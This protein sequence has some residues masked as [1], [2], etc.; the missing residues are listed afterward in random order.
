MIFIQWLISDFQLI[1]NN[2]PWPICI[3]ISQNSKLHFDFAK[4]PHSLHVLYLA[5]KSL[6][7]IAKLELRKLI[8]EKTCEIRCWRTNWVAILFVNLFWVKKNNYLLILILLYQTSSQLQRCLV[9]RKFQ[10]RIIA[11]INITMLV[12]SGHQGR[13][14][15]GSLV[16]T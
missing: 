12:L 7:A 6:S 11:G 3:K 15:D 4:I 1:S 5:K 8:I 16:G 10:P 9:L 14:V 13:G 2:S